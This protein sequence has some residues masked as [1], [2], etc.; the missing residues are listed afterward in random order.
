MYVT[1]AAVAAA[2]VKSLAPKF[3]FTLP[4]PE[5]GISLQ[6]FNTTVGVLHPHHNLLV[7]NYLRLSGT[8]R[9]CLA[10]L[11]SSPSSSSID[12]CKALRIYFVWKSPEAAAGRIP[13]RS[14]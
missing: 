1:T 3:H 8:I 4:P 13:P 7:S 5:G 10:E 14:H 12:T 9:N 2:K 11:N 6:P